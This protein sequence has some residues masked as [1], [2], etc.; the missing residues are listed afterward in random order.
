MNEQILPTTTFFFFLIQIKVPMR[1]IGFICISFQ[2]N[3]SSCQ[4]FYLQAGEGKRIN[5]ESYS[6]SRKTEQSPRVQSRLIGPVV[7][8]DWA[9]APAARAA[10]WELFTPC[11][12]RWPWARQSCG[13]ELGVGVGERG[14]RGASR[15]LPCA[16]HPFVL[17]LDHGLPDTAPLRNRRRTWLSR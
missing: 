2:F 9:A 13:A 5:K 15:P 3:L 8:S 7:K 6:C 4:I 12:N 16:V 17:R 11:V 10:L 1:W 14:L